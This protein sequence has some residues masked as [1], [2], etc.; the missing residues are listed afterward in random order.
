MKV[1]DGKAPML[2]WRLLGVHMGLL[3]HQ[4]GQCLA[5]IFGQQL[6]LCVAGRASSHCEHHVA[7]QLNAALALSG[8]AYK[9]HLLLWPIPLYPMLLP[10][11]MAAQVLAAEVFVEMARERVMPPYDLQVCLLPIICR[12]INKEKSEEVRAAAG[13]AGARGS[14]GH[15]E[16]LEGRAVLVMSQVCGAAKT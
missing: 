4:L 7:L 8:A 9:H 11:L 12:N 15:R 10:S 6:R 14:G 3:A 2:R 16:A 5:P 1:A 13:P